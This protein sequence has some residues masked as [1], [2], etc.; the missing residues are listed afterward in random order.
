MIDP[1]HLPFEGETPQERGTVLRVKSQGRHPSRPWYQN[2]CLVSLIGV[3]GGERRAD[4]AH[5]TST[6]W[7][8]VDLQAGLLTGAL[9][10]L[11]ERT[12]D[13]VQN[14][15]G[16]VWAVVQQ[17][18]KTG[19]L[20]ILRG[21]TGCG[22]DGDDA[23]LEPLAAVVSRVA[24][25]TGYGTSTSL[26]LDQLRTLPPGSGVRRGHRRVRSG[27]STRA[28]RRRCA[29]GGGHRPLPVRRGAAGPPGRPGRAT[30]SARD[31]QDDYQCRADGARRR[32]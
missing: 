24:T 27:R 9:A 19:P 25:K 28:V 2:T 8:L 18:P 17:N 7:V 32:P 3:T 12:V 23:L 11:A 4:S 21:W 14:I 10:E 13:A 31:Q 29:G 16:D 15:G 1:G 22:G 30:P 20:T 5:M 26:D 6:A